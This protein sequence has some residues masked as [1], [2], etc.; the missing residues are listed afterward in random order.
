MK[1]ID[2]DKLHYKTV[3]IAT[4]KGIKPAL[5]VFAKEIQKMPKIEMPEI[6]RHGHWVVERDE[7][8]MHCASC[9]WVF[10]YYGGL[11]EVYNFCPHCGAKMD[12]VEYE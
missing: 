2:A 6:V 1:I 8:V 9:A 3:R 10:E 5:V 4:Q 12:G 11:E 7:M